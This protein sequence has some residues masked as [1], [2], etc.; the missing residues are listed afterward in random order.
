MSDLARTGSWL[1]YTTAVTFT[2]PDVAAAEGI[3]EKTVRRWLRDARRPFGDYP[4]RVGRSWR[5]PR[6]AVENLHRWS[7]EVAPVPPV[8]KARAA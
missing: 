8:G 4:Y 6:A 3:C 5:I 1:D 7:R 2:V